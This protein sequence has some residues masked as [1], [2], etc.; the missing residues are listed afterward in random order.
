MSINECQL[1]LIYKMEQRGAG[2]SNF[3]LPGGDDESVGEEET[4]ADFAPFA[5]ATASAA[6]TRQCQPATIRARLLLDNVQ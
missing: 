3:T 4:L 2:M 5:N 1:T 6:P